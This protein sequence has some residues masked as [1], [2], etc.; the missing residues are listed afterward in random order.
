MTQTEALSRL[1]NKVNESGTGFY[2]DAQLYQMLDS[3]QN[4]VIMHFL[5]YEKRIRALQR[6]PEDA[7]YRSY[8]LACLITLDPSNTTSTSTPKYNLPT[9]YI[10][11]YR[12]AYNNIGSGPLYEAT[13]LSASE[14]T[15]REKNDYM[16]TTAILNASF[17]AEYPV[18]YTEGT[19][20]VFL[21][22]P[23]GEAANMYEH[24]YYKTPTAVSSG[25][26]FTLEE[27]THEAI[28]EYAHRVAREMDG[29]SGI[30]Q[31]ELFELMLKKLEDG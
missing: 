22:F 10:E 6:R 28:I 15:W 12:A 2:T 14:A 4:A 9:G 19:K 20:L 18:Y 3:G 26:A 23:S 13:Y 27:Y 1:R 8:V 24:W 31:Q 30:Q 5:G 16:K 17:H 7:H 21:P 29:Q 25:Q 11:S